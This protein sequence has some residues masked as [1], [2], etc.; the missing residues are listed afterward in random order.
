M[1][2]TIINEEIYEK[3]RNGLIQ[4]KSKGTAANKL[5]A[6][7]ASYK[8]GAKKVSEILDVDITS[9]YK[10]TIKLDR[11]GYRSLI[12]QAKHQDGIKLKKIHKERIRKWLEKD[13]NISITDI[14]EKIKNQF[15]IDLSK[16][17]I[18]RA[19]KDSGFSYITPRKNHYKQDKEKVENFK[20]KS[21]KGNKGR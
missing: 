20:K 18:H 10:W 9:I 21:S 7:M 5:K 1:P 13:P 14:K 8:H 19:M 3:A 4:L 17:T 11:E 16:S 12:N 2:K 15:N 6:I